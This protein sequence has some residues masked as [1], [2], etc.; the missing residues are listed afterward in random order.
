MSAWDKLKGAL[1]IDPNVNRFFDE[2][3]H[4]GDG[5]NPLLMGQAFDR[6]ASYFSVRL[7]EMFLEQR[8]KYFTD[9]LPLGICI[10]EFSRGGEKQRVPLVLSNELIK[11]KLT[12][13]G[14]DP[15]FVQ[16]RNMYVVRN[17]P[18]KADNL[19]LFIG[20][21]R[22]PYNDIAK[23]VLQLAA[24][25]TGELGGAALAGGLKIADKIY[26]GVAG[27]LQVN[28]VQP[29]FGYMDGSALTRGEYLVVAN[30][31]PPDLTGGSLCVVNNGLQ[32]IRGSTS[33]RA[34]GFDYC[35]LALEQA[36]SLFERGEAS[37]KALASLPFDSLWR[38]AIKLLA[39][40]KAEDANQ[41]LLGVR[42]AVVTSPDLIE[43]DRLLALAAY[44]TAYSKFQQQLLPAVP[45]ARPETRGASSA[46]TVEA[47]KA[48]AVTQ[49]ESG[50]R[51]VA[52]V[53][54]LM[55]LSQQIITPEG[56]L[57]HG[58][59]ERTVLAEAIQLR[60][61]LRQRGITPT[62]AITARLDEALTL[63]ANSSH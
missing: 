6:D 38:E 63:A 31:V 57:D 24:D 15:G 19:A 56:P 10:A 9:Y 55:A 33:R 50:Q 1:G 21:F 43:E 52:Q 5:G 59:P 51:D 48:E 49:T 8:E 35:L 41:A 3:F 53:L 60:K 7:V 26:D 47:L 37:I 11:E 61:E 4:D 13:N 12:G 27:L 34:E 42:A 40:N 46:P 28:N 14:R 32:I 29:R 16:F 36:G 25:V 20:L 30:G 39:L 18:F 44:N 22:V 17:V 45:A 23:Q 62:H 58:N 2:R 54:D